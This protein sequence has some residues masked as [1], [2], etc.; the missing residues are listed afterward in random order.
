MNGQELP[1]GEKAADLRRAFDRSFAEAPA[2]EQASFEDFLAIRVGPDPYAVSLAEISG[3]YAD[4]TVTRLPSPVSELLGITGFRGAIIAV[5]D[6]R[7]LLGYSTGEAPSWLMV[8]DETPI[9][10]AF[11]AFE[12]HLRF[13]RETGVH[14]GPA[15]H[16]RPYICGVLSTGD[17]IRP[18]VHVA[19]ILEAIKRLAQTVAPQQEE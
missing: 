18:V 19:P 11:D 2:A 3:L 13:P 10:L 6:L 17:A 15:E 7:A 4:R 16:T 8:A 9:G 14:A 12:G 1:L 5:Y